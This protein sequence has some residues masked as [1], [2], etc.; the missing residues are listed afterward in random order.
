MRL[1][2]GDIR[3]IEISLEESGISYQPGD[4]LRV[5]FDN[6]AALVAE[7]LVL[8]GLTGSESV[9]VEG[10][11]LALSEALT[12]HFELTCLHGGFIS[13]LA[14]LSDNAGVESHCRR[15][16]PD[17]GAGRCP[18]KSSRRLSVIRRY[19]PLSRAD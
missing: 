10:K 5:W 3:H 18:P 8:V 14:E 7:V 12:R 16:G 13:S 9:S 4:A 17:H 11:S 19:W 6:A 1:P 15:Q 2:P